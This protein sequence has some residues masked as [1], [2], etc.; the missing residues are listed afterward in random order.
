MGEH[1]HLEKARGRAKY[2]GEVAA[3]NCTLPEGGFAA[4]A[5]GNTEPGGAAPRERRRRRSK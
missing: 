5:A 4:E 1:E 3:S 2:N